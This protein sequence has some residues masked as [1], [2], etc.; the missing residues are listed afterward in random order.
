MKINCFGVHNFRSIKNILIK[1]PKNKP[2][3]LFGP[4]NAGKS[5]ILTAL[6]IALGESYPT[7]RTMEESDYYLRDKNTYPNI[8]FYCEFDAPYHSDKYNNEYNAIRKVQL[9]F[10]EHFY[11]LP[12]CV[13]YYGCFQ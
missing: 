1:F 12:C 6:S 8:E 2:L 10:L 7:Y 5:N 11:F 9:I 4:N 3:V 13:A